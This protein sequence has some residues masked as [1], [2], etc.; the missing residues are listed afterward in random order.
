M[1]I[2]SA[3]SV[4]PNAFPVSPSFELPF[5]P[6]SI[7]V[8]NEDTTPANAVELSFDGVNVHGKLIPTV[9]QGQKFEQ[10]TTKIWVRAVAGAPVVRIVAES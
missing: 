3:A 2:F 8:I 1:A 9:L 10:R 4:A 6:K 7:M 5:E